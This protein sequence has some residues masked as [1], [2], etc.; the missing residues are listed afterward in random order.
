MRLDER[1]ESLVVGQTYANNSKYAL[2]PYTNLAL[3]WA[4]STYQ[5]VQDFSKHNEVCTTLPPIVQLCQR[6]RGGNR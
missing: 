5:F 3:F 1:Q 4:P 2:S 6:Q